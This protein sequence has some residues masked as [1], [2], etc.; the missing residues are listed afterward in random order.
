MPETAP[1]PPP[2]SAAVQPDAAAGR[3]SLLGRDEELAEL[4]V[5]LAER[6]LVTLAGAPGIGKSRLGRELAVRAEGTTQLVELAVLT[7]PAQVPR[8]LA[9]ALSVEEVA[10]ERIVETLAAR[11]GERRL[12]I[13]LD[14]C[15]HVLAACSKLV[16]ALHAGC[17][18][19]RILATSREPLGLSAEHVWQVSPL[20]VPAPDADWESQELASYPAVALFIARAA[21][22]EPGFGLSAYVA[23]AVAEI[24]RRLDGIP[25]ALEL[26]AARVDSLTPQEI[27]AHL[28]DRFALL[29]KRGPAAYAR[30]ATL[31][32]ALDWSHELLAPA[33]RA[34]LR[35]LSVFAASFDAEGAAAVCVPGDAPGES[36]LEQEEVSEL[37]ARLT[38]KSLVVP[39]PDASPQPRYRLLETI[40]AYAA[41]R[42]EEAGETPALRRAHAGHYLALAERAEP[43]LTGPEQA[44]WF[45]RLDSEHANLRAAIEWSLSHGK[46]D[47]ALRLAGALVLFWHV[48]CQYGAGRELLGAA[49]S[50]GESEAAG[51]RAKALWGVGLMASMAGD[52]EGAVP[53]LDQCIGLCD[54]AGDQQVRARAL[55]SLGYCGGGGGQ[56][57][58]LP[59]L[60][61]SSELA[62]EVGDEW[63]HAHALGL[64]AFEHDA[65]G[66][67]ALARSLFEECLA[68]AR[69]SGDL[70]SLRYGL[71]GLG[72][73]CVS[74][75]EYGS[76]ERLLEEG[77]TVTTELGEDYGKA[78]ALQYLGR[79]AFRRGEHERARRLLEDALALMP[80]LGPRDARYGP[81]VYLAQVAAAQDDYGAARG[82]L[83][84]A[85]AAAP[86]GVDI[87][88]AVLRGMAEL[89]WAGGDLPAARRLLEQ[90]LASARRTGGGEAV[91]GALYALAELSRTQDDLKAAAELHHEALEIRR[92]SGNVPGIVASIEAVAGVD[93]AAGRYEHAARLLGA[94][95]ALREANGYARPAPESS[96]YEAYVRLLR[97]R[98]GAER[99]DEAVT[100]GA[101]LS[102]EEAVCEALRSRDRRGRPPS[103]WPSLT[104]SERQVARLAGAGLT[105]PEIAERLFLSLSTVK[106]HLSNILRKLGIASRREIAHEVRNGDADA[107]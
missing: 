65:R 58:S 50:A 8:A 84:Q 9:A 79:L 93:P 25:L 4:A 5:L 95:E 2:R 101:A 100:E 10:G 94:A 97:Q 105:N 14:N 85:L 30:H 19:L 69:E 51:L 20:A 76:A 52:I 82:F 106:F 29:R 6:R 16:A 107:P 3:D 54:D 42:L 74:Q 33:E 68:V 103:G 37:L 11:I 72:F 48:R 22:G 7:R 26:A 81:F 104:P 67:H 61:Q 80:E 12:L 86:P 71:I 28:D 77:V 98:L 15:E 18:E 56:R 47:W 49:L 102:I 87:P 63:C 60:E 41:E 39:E 57:Q 75:G 46:P 32:A 96:R 59:P 78:T 35:R 1:R 55:L 13:V 40:R 70:Q 92:Q 44:V 34:L 73:V 45:K 62:R 64:A 90:A 89:A 99:F 53:R 31:A 24:C 43:K 38:S 17:P 66:E 83:D 88:D 91:A 27:E 21:Q 23:P 36:E